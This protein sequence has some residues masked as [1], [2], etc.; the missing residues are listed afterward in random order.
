M[1]Y[2]YY[3][4]YGADWT[5]Y[6]IDE[7]NARERVFAEQINGVVVQHDTYWND[8]SCPLE[9]VRYLT[10]AEVFLKLL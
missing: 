6:E 8:I 4:E 9:N 10:K 7:K 1:K 5:I 3:D 2:E